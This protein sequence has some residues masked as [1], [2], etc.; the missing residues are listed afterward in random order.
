MCGVCAPVLTVRC[1]SV[2][3]CVCA[4]VCVCVCPATAGDGRA[5]VGWWGAQTRGRPYAGV[6]ARQATRPPVGECI[7]WR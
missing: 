4:S 3:V 5:A 6:V 7:R 2:R 1:P